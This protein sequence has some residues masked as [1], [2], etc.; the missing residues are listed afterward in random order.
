[1]LALFSVQIRGWTIALMWLLLPASLGCRNEAPP[2]TAT[3]TDGALPIE[4]VSVSTTNILVTLKLFPRASAAPW[5]DGNSLEFRF[6]RYSPDNVEEVADWSLINMHAENFGQITRRL[7]MD[8][9]EVAVVHNPQ[10]W[11]TEEETGKPPRRLLY[12]TGYAVVIDHR[13]GK[14]WFSASRASRLNPG[15]LRLEQAFPDKFGN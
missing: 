9:V 15:A 14:K 10:E 6:R 8:T 12:D 3:T 13:I 2:R 5:A 7:K 4:I 1:M 11:L